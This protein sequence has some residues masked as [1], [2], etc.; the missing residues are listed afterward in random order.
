[1]ACPDEL[2]LELWLAG[3]L[4]PDEAAPIAEHVRGCAACTAT[5]EATR[6]LEAGLRAALVLDAGEQTYLAGLELAAGWRGRQAVAEP[7]WGWIA[8]AGAVGGYVAW[9]AAEGTVGP[10]AATALQVG[11]GTL[12][13]P[14]ALET[15]F[16][17]GQGL[18]ELSRHPALGLSQ[19]LLALLALALLLWPRQPIPQ[20]STQA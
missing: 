12:P 18:L 20:R 19:P 16:A 3:A 10:A 11:L 4:P 17:L 9:S 6:A 5:V 7:P 15:L 2:T 1:M 8:L 14:L 13:L